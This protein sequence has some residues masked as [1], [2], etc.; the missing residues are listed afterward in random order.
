MIDGIRISQHG[1]NFSIFGG[2]SKS[3]DMDFLDDTRMAAAKATLPNGEGPSNVTTA[4]PTKQYKGR[5]SNSFNNFGLENQRE[6]TF[7]L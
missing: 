3:L 1:C 5:L 6:K 4:R 7:R 2:V